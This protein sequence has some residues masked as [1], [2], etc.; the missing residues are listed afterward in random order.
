MDGTKEPNDIKLV[1]VLLI[2]GTAICIYMSTF[3]EA[4]RPGSDIVFYYTAENPE[5]GMLA[6][7]LGA[8]AYFSIIRFFSS[9]AKIF[10]HIFEIFSC[11]WLI[12]LFFFCGRIVGARRLV[13][14]SVVFAA[15]LLLVILRLEIAA[16]AIAFMGI[17]LF[18]SGKR[19]AGW[20]LV[21]AAAFVK[22]FPAFLIP[23]LFLFDVKS[24]SGRKRI[25]ASVLFGV[26]LLLFSSTTINAL[27]YQSQRRVG[28]ESIYANGVLL[29]NTVNPLG[30]NT[31]YSSGSTNVVLPERLSRMTSFATIGQI[32]AVLL[33]LLI[34]I[35]KGI[36]EEKI[37]EYSFMV[38]AVAVF[39]AKIS[40][41]QFVLWPIA[42]AIPLMEKAGCEKLFMLVFSLSVIAAVVYPFAW[43]Y[44]ITMNR[45][46]LIP[47]TLKNIILLSVIVYVGRVTVIGFKHE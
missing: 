15:P 18:N 2:W 5:G 43:P 28:I 19:M 46:A 12:L 27:I 13:E 31:E 30:I 34:F 11:L 14:K 24:A 22:I 42:F 35:L 45:Y 6:Y 36:D 3:K 9:N 44:V 38:L 23:L 39:A 17:Y 4:W 16:V 29:I 41:A 7:P 40:S 25:L 37:W 8:L 20:I 26:L 10:A 32:V 21:I 1:L 33:M 47:L